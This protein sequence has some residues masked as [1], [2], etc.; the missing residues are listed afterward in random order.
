[1]GKQMP[2]P[3]KQI[4]ELLAKMKITQLEPLHSLIV[5][6]FKI[7]PEHITDLGNINLSFSLEIPFQIKQNYSNRGEEISNFSYII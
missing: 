5:S 7:F 2:L 3:L 4:K 6:Q 1:M